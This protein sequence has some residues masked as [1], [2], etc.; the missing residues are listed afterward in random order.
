MKSFDFGLRREPEG[1]VLCIGLQ[2]MLDGLYYLS[3][4]LFQGASLR[5]ATFDLRGESVV[6]V[7]V[8]LDNDAHSIRHNRFSLLWSVHLRQSLN[9]AGISHPSIPESRNGGREPAVSVCA[10]A[11]RCCKYFTDKTIR[12]CVYSISLIRIF[13]TSKRLG[14]LRR[15]LLCS[16][17]TREP[18]ESRRHALLILSPGGLRKNLLGS[19]E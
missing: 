10:R 19:W 2:V 4:H 8:S 16:M 17:K 5:L 13:N 3:D 1:W 7:L 11:Q 15:R 18:L 6:S 12:F 9:P 14:A